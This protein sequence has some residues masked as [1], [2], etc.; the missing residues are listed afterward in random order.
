MKQQ[1]LMASNCHLASYRYKQQQCLMASNCYLATYRYK[2]QQCLMAS[3]CHLATYRCKQQQ[4][5]M[6]SNHHIATQRFKQQHLI[7][8]F[9]YC[10]CSNIPHMSVLFLLVACS[11]SRGHIRAGNISWIEAGIQRSTWQKCLA[12]VE[13]FQALKTTVVSTQL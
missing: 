5:L 3:N 8:L 11:S 9:R 2:Q 7:L 13:T 12:D 4:C 10:Y 6:A 1:C